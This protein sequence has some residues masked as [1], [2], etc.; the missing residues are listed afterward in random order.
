QIVGAIN[1]ASVHRVALDIPSGV[2][3]DTGA[4]LGVAVRAHD[5][6]TFACLK[7]GLLTPD[8]A[9]HAGRVHVVDLGV[10]R[11]VV[12]QVGHVAEVIERAA[13]ASWL[14]PREVDVHKHAAGNLLAVAGSVG[15]LG[16]ALLVG[17]GAL[18]AGAGLVTLAC[19][20]DAA[21]ALESRV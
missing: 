21:P 13:V 3:A 16:A 6:V 14:K 4:P 19:W 7:M 8:G 9:K 2:D 5:T 1:R 12:D 10:P 11:V 18:R 17:R 20:S 15:K